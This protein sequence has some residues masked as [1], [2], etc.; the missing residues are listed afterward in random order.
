MQQQRGFTL[1]EM[2]ITI[3]L[4]LFFLAFT[5]M[6]LVRPQTQSSLTTTAAV[7]ISDLQNQQL[8]A[9]VNDGGTTSVPSA[10]GIY[11]ESTKYTL[12]QG[13]SFSAGQASNF[14]VKLSPDIEVQQ[15]SF[16]S[17]TVIF[18]QRS[19]EVSG[20]NPAGNSF[21]VRSTAS[22]EQKIISVNKYGVVTLQ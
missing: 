3:T 20:Y 16:P 21:V 12:F 10:Y 15:V 13:S 18:S 19:G 5:A 17:S 6:N 2:M 9:M 14:E 8:K 4:F 11:F 7:I 22:N 1:V